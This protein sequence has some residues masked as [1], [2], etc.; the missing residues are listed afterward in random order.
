VVLGA[1]IALGV[2]AQTGTDRTDSAAGLK[3]RNAEPLAFPQRVSIQIGAS[4]ALQLTGVDP[5]AEDVDFS[6]EQ[7][8]KMGN[9]TN[10]DAE[11]GTVTYNALPEV[12]GVDVFLFSAKDDTLSS[13]PASVVVEIVN[14]LIFADGFESGDTDA[15]NLP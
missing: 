1:L 14:S 8:P 9:L 4:V 12:Q 15:W 5:E 6:I 2:A 7:V 10:F 13:P 3:A 11:L